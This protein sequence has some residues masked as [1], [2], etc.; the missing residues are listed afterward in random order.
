MVGSGTVVQSVRHLGA[1]SVGVSSSLLARSASS[2]RRL[3][4]GSSWRRRWPH[5][6]APASRACSGSG[7]P[8]A[9]RPV[10]HQCA[11]HIPPCEQGGGRARGSG[12]NTTTGR[13]RQ[14]RQQGRRQR[15]CRAAAT[16][17]S[18]A[19]HPPSRLEALD[20]DE[21]V[22]HAAGASPIAR[23]DC[24]RRRTWSWLWVCASEEDEQ[25]RQTS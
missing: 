7:S 11:A 6:A 24:S 20:T 1:W 22:A 14:R 19:A 21:L 10:R 25:V 13:R 3:T 23:P 17:S 15:R 12:M 5:S 8:L 16:G 4:A 18:G 9:R 2:A